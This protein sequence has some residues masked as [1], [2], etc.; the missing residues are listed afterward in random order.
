MIRTTRTMDFTLSKLETVHMIKQTSIPFRRRQNYE[1]L[2]LSENCFCT[3][4]LV[5]S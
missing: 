2:I 3:F 4:R 5:K 1:R